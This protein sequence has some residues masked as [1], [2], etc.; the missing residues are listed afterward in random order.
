MSRD[1]K[2]IGV[3]FRDQFLEDAELLNCTL[4]T[5]TVSGATLTT[6]TLTNATVTNLTVSGALTIDNVPVSAT[7]ND[8]TQTAT[9]L[10]ISGTITTGALTTAADAKTSV[11]LTLVGA[12]AGDLAFITLAGGTNTTNVAVH[13][14]IVTT[15]T[16]TVI[17][18]NDVASVTA[19]N[20]TVA[21]HYLLVK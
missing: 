9:V 17:L 11:V 16:I 4:T 7:G 3:A 6:P 8:T 5:P 10:K 14:A 1:T 12:A 20:G 2:S 15:N 21:F 18:R 13:S 19:L